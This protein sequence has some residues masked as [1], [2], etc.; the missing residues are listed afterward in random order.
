MWVSSYP[1]T[2][3]PLIPFKLPGSARAP[4]YG[5]TVWTR[6]WSSGLCAGGSWDRPILRLP[7][8][9][10]SMRLNCHG[11]VS[12][13]VQT[14][15]DSAGGR[16]FC[17]VRWAFTA[18]TYTNR[19]RQR[20]T[21]THTRLRAMRGHTPAWLHDWRQRSTRTARGRS[22]SPAII[23]GRRLMCALPQPR[24]VHSVC[25]SHIRVGGVTN[26]EAQQGTGSWSPDSAIQ[27]RFRTV[28]NV[29]PDLR[30]LPLGQRFTG[31]E[32]KICE[33][34]ASNDVRGVFFSAT[35]R[36]RRSM[37]HGQTTTTVP[38]TSQI[39]LLP[40]GQQ[41]KCPTTLLKSSKND[42]RWQGRN[43]Y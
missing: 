7:P 2:R 26:G 41:A 24:P 15:P 4:L 21:H 34:E 8:R 1:C 25:C 18:G 32:K 42:R 16:V 37:Y 6:A 23:V 36:G 40:R 12:R 10:L 9:S 3:V 28:A 38:G 30:R 33:E 20:H 31:P 19:Y 17:G 11:N 35:E 14:R 29:A 39:K 43:K 5:L 22:R 13:Q 27:T